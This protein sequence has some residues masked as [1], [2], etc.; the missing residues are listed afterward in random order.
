MNI[1]NDCIF[2]TL[3]PYTS[4]RADLS[5]IILN[6]RVRACTNPLQIEIRVMTM[7]MNYFCGM[8]DPA[9][10]IALFPAGTTV[11]DS[12]HR[13]FATRREQDKGKDITPKSGLKYFIFTY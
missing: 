8:V 9:K 7:M 6:A 11:R 12:H 2:S 10:A 13:K 5:T 4:L 3:A 1:V